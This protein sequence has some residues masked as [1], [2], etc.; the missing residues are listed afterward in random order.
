MHQ[1]WWRWS[2]WVFSAPGRRVALRRMTT[3]MLPTGGCLLLA[4]ACG[5]PHGN[6]LFML[7]RGQ[8][9]RP[10]QERVEG[11]CLQVPSRYCYSQY[12]RFLSEGGG[13]QYLKLWEPWRVEAQDC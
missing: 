2:S 11:T 13:I 8:Y 12:C 3:P 10:N 5:V 6:T 1:D 9:D 7:W 4:G